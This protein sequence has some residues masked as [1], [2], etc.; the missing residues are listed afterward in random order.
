MTKAFI[1]RALTALIA[2]P[3]AIAIVFYLSPD[4]VFL[5]SLGVFFW[6]AIEFVRLARSYAPSAPIGLLLILFPAASIVTFRFLSLPT[7]RSP[8]LGLFSAFFLL[9]FSTSCCV[10]L[11]RTEMRDGLPA[12]GILAFAL[13]YFSAPPLAVYHLR[14]IDPWLVVVLLAIVWSGD[15]AAY[16]VGSWVGRHK[17]APTV[18]P[19]KTWE[20]AAASFLAAIITISLW[21]HL[22]LGRLEPGLLL[23][24]ASASIGAQ[25][26]DLVESMV[27][28]GAGVKDS[29]NVLP[30]HGGFYDRLDALIL[31]APVFLI[32]CWILGFERL[33]PTP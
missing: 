13:P 17:M 5:C 28:R 27:K 7:A 14:V 20:G 31:A 26:G 33:L 24:A 30:G 11:A 12:I 19:N 10:L 15:T 3:A 8:D 32:G 4:L 23:V 9:I 25:I 21:S 22:R 16:F 29:S 1:N 2:A 18:S 6:A